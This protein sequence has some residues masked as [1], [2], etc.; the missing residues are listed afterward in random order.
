M[1]T[2]APQKVSRHYIP[3]WSPP[4]T[5]AEIISYDPEARNGL[6]LVTVKVT[7]G[8]LGGCKGVVI[9]EQIRPVGEKEKVTQTPP[10]GEVELKV[11]SIRAFD[12]MKAVVVTVTGFP[13]GSYLVKFAVHDKDGHYLGVEKMHSLLEPA[14]GPAHDVTVWIGEKFKEV[15]GADCSG[16]LVTP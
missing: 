2:R 1:F 5:K 14:T 9:R 13:P 6:G 10:S 12:L 7:E 3:V 8:Q 4:S 11:D 15:T 16:R